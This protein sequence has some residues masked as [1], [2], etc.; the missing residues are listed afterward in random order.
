[1]RIV[2][3]LSGFVALCW[4]LSQCSTLDKSGASDTADTLARSDSQKVRALIRTDSPDERFR[5]ESARRAPNRNNP[6]IDPAWLAHAE[7]ARGTMLGVQSKRASAWQFVGP[8][9]LAGRTRAIVIEPKP[10]YRVYAGA[11]SGGVFESSD[12][13]LTWRFAGVGLAHLSIGALAM[14]PSNSRVMLAGTGELY[15][16]TAH[17]YSTMRGGGV[18][19][20]LDGAAHW[21]PWTGTQNS[22]FAYVSDLKISPQDSNRVYIASNSGVWRTRDGGVSFERLL[23]P[24]AGMD[25]AQYEGCTELELRVENSA[26]VL[27]ASCSSR[28]V[29]DRY[30]LSGTLSGE[31]CNGPCPAAIFISTDA[32]AASVNFTPVLSEPGM[33]RTSIA[34]APSQPRT[35]YGLSASI[36]E[37]PDRDGD[38]V[39]DYNNGLHALFRSD[40]GGQSWR[41]QLR[42]TSVSDSISSY[43]L[44]NLTAHENSRCNFGNSSNFFL[45]AG[46][47]DQTIAV[48]PL[49][50]ER[51][52]VGGIDLFRSDDGGASFGIASYWWRGRNQTGFDHA[53]HHVLSFHPAYDGETNRKLYAGNDGGVSLTT[54]ARAPVMRGLSAPCGPSGAMTQFRAAQAGLGSSQ[55]YHGS[56]ASDGQRMLAGAQ[57]NGTWFF[58]RSNWRFAFGGDG[59]YNAIDPRDSN[60]LY[61]SYQNGNMFR[62]DDGAVR[63]EESFVSIRSGITDRGLFVTPFELDLA[64]PDTVWFGTTRVWRS[65]N[66]GTTWVV[67]SANFGLGFY[68]QINA[69]ATHKAVPGLVVAATANGIYRNGVAYT[70]DSN[71]VWTNAKPREGWVSSLSFD[72]SDAGVLYATYS[73]FGGAHVYR[74]V[75]AGISFSAIDGNLPDLPV[76]SIVVDPNDSRRLYIGTDLGLFVSNDTGATWSAEQTGFGAAIVEKLAINTTAPHFLH[77]FTYGRGVWRSALGNIDFRTIQSADAQYTG[78]WYNPDLS[79]QGLHLEVLDSN[80]DPRL[81]VAW[82][83]YQNGKPAWFYGVGPL[84]GNR[85]EVQLQALT[86]GQ[87]PPAFAS[88]QVQ[89]NAL[90]KVTVRFLAPDRAELSFPDTATAQTQILMLQPLARPDFN[91]PRPAATLSA[92]HTGNWYNPAQSGHGLTMVLFPRGSNTEALFTWYV[93]LDGAPLY[94]VG[95]A[96]TNG[97]SVTLDAYRTTGAQFGSAFRPSDVRASLFGQVTFSVS[98]ANDALLRWQAIDPAIGSGEMP[99]TRLTQAAGLACD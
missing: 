74:S 32:S 97:N 61:L 86:G 83:S 54:D 31:V 88:S 89:Q 18:Y 59:S 96:T 75:D 56:V 58:D 99:M 76:H 65:R 93:Y 1:M 21:S 35:L 28:S 2:A 8:D 81:L 78:H 67:A 77:A 48:D 10:P 69:I 64:A 44:H 17:P 34:V 9:Q 68:D 40:D 63:G 19:K 23:R 43:L 82:Y 7:R 66:R 84:L 91:A 80:E 12:E 62:A 30:Y 33:G 98:G 95:N 92:C 94:L 60:R 57:D 72:P 16:N 70:S 25:T 90:G 42:N 4:C 15:R 71:S 27:L 41:A 55:F 87:F 37:G 14:D 6:N 49:S 29:A 38:G 3:A 46:W 39:G 52:W 5:W 47:Y 73:N 50:P 85:G 26:E 36:L 53:D 51:V 11:A 45:T 20:S 24:S 79:G 13:G 22:D